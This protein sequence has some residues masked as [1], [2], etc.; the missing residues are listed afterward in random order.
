MKKL[1]SYSYRS[2][3]WILLCFFLLAFPVW[4]LTPEQEA[5]DLKQARLALAMNSIYNTDIST[6]Y[7]AKSAE[8]LL[9][10]H[11]KNDR[12]ARYYAPEQFKAFLSDNEGEMV[13]LGIYFSLDEEGRVVVNGLVPN[14]PGSKS[15]IKEGSFITHID[16]KPLL[17][18]TQ[19]DIQILFKGEAGTTVTITV[20]YHGLS[21]D[22][23]M[24]R[25]QIDLISIESYLEKPDIGYIH[26]AD[27]HTNTANQ[28][29]Q[30]LSELKKQ[31]AKSLILDLRQCPGGTLDSVA[32]ISG[33]FMKEGPVVFIRQKGDNEYFLKT[34]NWPPLGM[35]LAV[36][37]NEKTASAAELLAAN[38][39]DEKAGILIGTQTFGKGVMQSVVPLPSGAGI[40][41]TTGQYFSRGYQNVDAN[42]GVTPDLIVKGEDAQIKEAVKWLKLQNI[43]GKKLSFVMNHKIMFVDGNKVLINNLPFAEKGNCYVPIKSS[44]EALG[45]QVSYYGGNYYFQKNGQKISL[46][47][48]TGIYTANGLEGKSKIIEKNGSS[49]LSA[50]F[51][52]DVLKCQVDWNAKT[53]TLGIRLP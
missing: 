49:Y 4:A 20:D 41:F 33:A 13:G 45:Y 9:K 14:S 23:I 17:G 29:N 46:A 15:D 1:I 50:G 10:N 6:S 24:I 25:T 27:F 53:N 22:Y 52:R 3:A 30:A 40:V 21:K 28:L 19:E 34:G 7:N 44:M 38:I 2:L 31:G 35:P 47:V 26:I 12:W 18:L 37:V 11:A 16:G 42:K 8:E 43:S 32:D 39:Q 51:F 5:E 48:K 36:L